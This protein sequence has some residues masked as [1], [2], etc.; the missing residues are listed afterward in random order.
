[1]A[2]SIDYNYHVEDE[3]FIFDKDEL[4]IGPI[5]RCKSQIPFNFGLSNSQGVISI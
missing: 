5:L 1:M 2:V 3:I 4:D